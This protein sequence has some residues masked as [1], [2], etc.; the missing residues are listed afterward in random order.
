MT[1]RFRHLLP[2][3]LGGDIGAYA[4]ARQLHE[5]TGTS[6]TVVASDPIVAISESVYITVVHQE[7]GAPP[8]RT[9]ALLRQLAQG[10]GPRSAVLMANTDAA[11]AMISAHR[12][13]LEPTYVLPF[14]DID[15]LDAVSD[16]ASFSRLCAEV[17]VLTPREVVVDLADPDCEPPTSADEL[18]MEFP[19]VAKAAIGADYDRIS[20]PGKRKIWFIDDAAELAGM[21]RSLKEAG[22]RS[23][24]LVQECIPGDDTAMRSVTAYMDSTGELR[25]I[26]SA[27][28]L[29]QD[30]APTMIGNPVAMMTEAFPDLWEATGRLLRHAGYRGF[31]NLDIKVDP[32]DGREL[33]FEVNPRIGRN[34]F[35]LTAAGANPWP[36]CSRTWSWTSVTSP[37]RSP[38][39]SSTPWSPTASSHA[40]C[41]MRRCA[42]RPRAWG[43]ASIR[44][45][46]RPSDRFAG[47]SR[48]SSSASTTTASSPATIRNE[49]T[50][51]AECPRTR[52]CPTAPPPTPRLI[53]RLTP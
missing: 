42:A 45:A 36:S 50:G 46:T 6:V 52:T 29:L 17:G 21:W 23:T 10:R 24:F 33:F 40:T 25:L 34:S 32:R 1:Q 28:V 30:H 19:L 22:Y 3:V 4:L 12:S 27:R 51:P 49:S 20:F 16:K 43:G 18:G 35:Y 39:R 48:S 5:V 44:C 53:P 37:S 41:P 31:A 8:E 11:A 38:D 9:I 15:V 26:G 2:V 13:E 47:A 7:A 14:P